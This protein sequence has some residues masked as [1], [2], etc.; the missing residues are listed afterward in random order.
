MP[1]RQGGFEAVHPEN[2]DG[3]Q[4]A[5]GFSLTRADST[6]NL[7]ALLSLA[8][9]RELSMGLKNAVGPIPTLGAEMDFAGTSHASSMP[10]AAPTGQ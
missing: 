8:H 10:N 4:N 3:Y 1:A 7:R 9:Q 6:A 2:V 5:T